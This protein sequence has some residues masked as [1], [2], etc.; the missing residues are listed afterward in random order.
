[1]RLRGNAEARGSYCAADDVAGAADDSAGAAEDAAGA[2]ELRSV[3]GADGAV[4]APL[5]AGAVTAG[6]LLMV[7]LS[8]GAIGVVVVSAGAVLVTGGVV[9]FTVVDVDGCELAENTR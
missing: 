8:A 1:M 4:V 2:A 3:A 9:L 5:S 7:V 6:V